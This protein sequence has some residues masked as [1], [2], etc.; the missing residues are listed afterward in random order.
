MQVGLPYSSMVADN[1]SNSQVFRA[2]VWHH[3]V[4]QL[5]LNEAG[6][7]NGWSRILVDGSPV[8]HTRNYQFRALANDDSLIQGL[9]FSTF[10]GGD[11]ATWSPQT[12]VHALFDNFRVM[13]GIAE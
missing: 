6:M 1:V 5:R 8:A 11:D 10:H 4:V 9:L 12:T 13:S 3:V 2:G 7:A